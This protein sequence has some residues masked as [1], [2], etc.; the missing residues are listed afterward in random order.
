MSYSISSSFSAAYNGKRD[1]CEILLRAFPDLINTLTVERW[2]PLHAAC[3]NGHA[4][5]LFWLI[6][7]MILQ[8]D[9]ACIFYIWRNN[10]KRLTTFVCFSGTGLSTKISI[11]KRS[12][13]SREGSKFS[14]GILSAIRYQSKGC[15]WANS[16]LP[17]VLCRKF[18][19]CRVTF[20]L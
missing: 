3:I 10:H 2:S 11:S 8:S 9:K 20:E 6:C 15:E 17:S 12:S 1:V 14:T 4:G 19:D 13:T 5:M 18:E 16:P 7:C